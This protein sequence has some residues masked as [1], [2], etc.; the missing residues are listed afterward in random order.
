MLLQNN[1]AKIRDSTT[2]RIQ[3]QRRTESRENEHHRGEPQRPAPET[4][5]SDADARQAHQ[6]QRHPARPGRAQAHPE[7]ERGSVGVQDADGLGEAAAVFYVRGED[8]EQ[9][10]QQTHRHDSFLASAET[11]RGAVEDE[12]LW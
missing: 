5:Q 4:V 2:T 12:V 9:E 11:E 8:G 10:V 7:L 3:H 1:H 6:E